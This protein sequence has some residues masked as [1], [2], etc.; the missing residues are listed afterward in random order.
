MRVKGQGYFD[1]RTGILECKDGDVLMEGR[2][3]ESVRTGIFR[4][5]DGDM[6]V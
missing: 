3:Y 6:R 2:G 1:E 4:W 5:K